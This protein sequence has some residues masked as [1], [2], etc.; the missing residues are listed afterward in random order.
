MRGDVR[1]ACR[2]WTGPPGRDVLLLHGLA[3]HAGEWDRV[4][5]TLSRAGR[6]V[7]FDQ[8]GHGRSTRRPAEVSRAAYVADVVAAV[9]QLGLRQPLLVGQSLGGH[10]ALLAAAAHPGLFGGLV[11]VE[12]GPGAA[13]GAQQEIAAVLDSWP[14]P[15]PSPEAAARF[16]GGG[17]V[18]AVWADGLEPRDGSWWP[19]F[20][21]DVM[22]ASLSE[23]A[24]RSY[25]DEW[26]AIDRPALL[27]L[28]QHGI[29][30]PAEITGMLRRRPATTA[31]SV[32]GAGHDLHLEHPDLLARLLADFASA[33]PADILPPSPEEIPL[34]TT[35][36]TS[37][38]VISSDGT[39]IACS[40]TGTGPAVVIVDGALCHRAFGPG[41]AIADQ[42]AAHHT[43]HTYDRR[44]RGGSGD[45]Q[46]FAVEREIEDLAAVIAAAG[47]SAHVVALSSGAA[48]ALRA[49]TQGVGIARLAVYEPPFSTDDL[50]SERF[51]AYRGD[52]TAALA[53][54]R[55]GDAAVRFMTFAG[56]P[57]EVADG[58]RNAPVWPLFEAVAPT[59]AHDAE[60]LGTGARVPAEAL[61]RITAP[62]LVVDG[63][64]SPE[65]LRAAARAVEAAVPG[66]RRTT[67][68][69]QTHEVA[70]EVLAPALLAFFA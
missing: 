14:V 63:G 53:D 13:P 10:T 17:A 31:V 27:V 28:G 51:D 44:G 24:H 36:S 58:M 46:P 40:T 45:T 52:L 23:L 9:G 38:S 29:L 21:R 35:T 5:A 6:V 20:D 1:L 70:A 56:M 11:L 16:F 15:F 30:P 64:A 39:L 49:A 67:L 50:Q 25:W 18:G 8:R 19:R 2:D 32:P 43:V 68:E 69:G 41:S 42:L 65:L 59:L 37:T 61:A 7:A 66:A 48:L 34:T 12:A 62:V 47:G 22:V 55:R 26:T 33:Q 57:P 4:A 3:G 60:A 54:G